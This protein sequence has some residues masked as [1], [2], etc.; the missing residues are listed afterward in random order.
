MLFISR[1][2]AIFSSRP[3]AVLLP[4][5]STLLMGF[6]SSF[7]APAEVRLTNIPCD[8]SDFFLDPYESVLH[9]VYFTFRNLAPHPNLK[10]MAINRLHS[11]HP[12]FKPICSARHWFLF[13]F[14]ILRNADPLRGSEFTFFTLGVT[15]NNDV[16][17]YCNIAQ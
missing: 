12:V 1:P 16:L 3:Y 17:Q 14:D 4:N 8:T 2:Y 5:I 13:V 11:I 9:S 10:S 15:R 6:Q 7:L